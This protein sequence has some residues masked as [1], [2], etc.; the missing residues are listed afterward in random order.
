[1]ARYGK[2]WP[3]SEGDEVSDNEVWE[4]LEIAQLSQYL[5]G[6]REGLDTLVGELELS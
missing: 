5:D 3:R 4:A 2:R 1:M 6:S